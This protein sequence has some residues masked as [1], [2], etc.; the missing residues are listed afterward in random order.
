MEVVGLR[1]D[2]ELITT[3]A[4]GGCMA[5]AIEQQEAGLGVVVGLWGR[6]RLSNG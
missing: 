4:R 3:V 2:E 5:M 6:A 1:K